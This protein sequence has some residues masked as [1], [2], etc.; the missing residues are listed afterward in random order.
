MPVG[1]HFRRLIVLLVEI[2]FKKSY[3]TIFFLT[4]MGSFHSVF[5]YIRSFKLDISNTLTWML[6]HF[7]RFLLFYHNSYST[8]HIWNKTTVLVQIWLLFSFLQMAI[9]FWARNCVCVSL[10]GLINCFLFASYGVWYDNHHSL[11]LLFCVAL[12]SATSVVSLRKVLVP[13]KRRAILSRT[14]WIIFNFVWGWV[15]VAMVRS[16]FCDYMVTGMSCGNL[17]E[18]QG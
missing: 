6:H 14:R 3:M 5:L 1:I 7:R 9:F 10:C 17:F 18:K 2:S 8:Q 11:V 16:H 15:L 13:L 4:W 12:S